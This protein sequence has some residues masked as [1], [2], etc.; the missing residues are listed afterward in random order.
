MTQRKRPP[1]D[2]DTL[3][4]VTGIRA[5]DAA[6]QEPKGETGPGQAARPEIYAGPELHETVAAA[7]QALQQEPRLYQRGGMLVH[8]LQDVCPMDGLLRSEP[9][10]RIVAITAHC[11]REYM[12]E[13][14]SWSR[15]HYSRRK[16]CPP[17]LDVA[18]ALIERGHYAEIRPL[19]GLTQVPVLRPD[20]TLLQAPGYDPVTGLLYLPSTTYPPISESPQPN[21]VR[22]SVEMLLEVV[23]DFPIESE[24]HQAAWLA[25]VLT[26]LARWA[27]SGPSPLFLFDANVRGA[28]KTLLAS[29]TG[30]LASGREPPIMTQAAT[31]DELRK[32]ITA[33]V[34]A[35]ESLVLLDNVAGRLGSPTLDAALT[36]SEWTDRMLGVSEMRTLP[37]SMTWLATGNNVEPVADTARRILPIRLE[38]PLERPEERQRFQHADLRAWVRQR[39]PVLVAAGLTLLRGYCAAGRPRQSLEGWGS[40]ESWSELVRGCVVWCG[41]PDPSTARADL[42]STGDTEMSALRRLYVQWTSVDPGRAGLTASELLRALERNQG[43][44]HELRDALEELAPGRNGRPPSSRSLGRRLARYRRRI[45]IDDSGPHGKRRLWLDCHEARGGKRWAVYSER[46]EDLP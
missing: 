35:G 17:P 6:P 40:F 43:Q 31:D 38:S 10:P 18:R 36:A 14:A 27:F 33:L 37:L 15:P 26:P 29:V 25:A 42:I 22:R 45:I 3:A 12:S 20:G 30:F 19:E 7:L 28:G 1:I 34:V 44:H 13:A 23:E 8:V 41:L 4:R 5:P 32:R 39:R 9:S 16:A 46:A 21:E 11:L 2:R 24:A